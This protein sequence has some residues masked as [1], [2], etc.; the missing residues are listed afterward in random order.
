MRRRAR[1]VA[2]SAAILAAATASGALLGCGGSTGSSS[3][4]RANPAPEGGGWLAVAK[5]WKSGIY[6][7]VLDRSGRPVARLAQHPGWLDEEPAWSPDGEQIAFTRSTNGRRSFQVFLTNAE[8]GGVRRLTRGRYD[9]G[10]AWSPNGEWLAYQSSTGVR[11]IHPNGS[12]DRAVP[13]TREASYPAWS[14]NGER[15]AFS[16]GRYIWSA[17]PDG[18]GRRRIV[19]GREPDF[20]PDGHQLAYTLPN[21][22]IGLVDPNG[23]RRRSLGKGLE[24]DWSPEGKKLA[25]TRWPPS[26]RFSVW[27]MG[28]DG[29]GRRLLIEGA[30]SP[31]WRP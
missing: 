23:T 16:Q 14:P 30:R 4:A 5:I 15:L 19:K 22:G 28:S 6:I 11:L 20:S 12:G 29:S 21:G 25:F 9:G 3:P 18:S 10:A 2:L 27:T 31:D 13:G 8:G 17:L 24:P 1:H 7:G 26:L